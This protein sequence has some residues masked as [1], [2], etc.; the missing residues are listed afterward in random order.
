MK[1]ALLRVAPRALEAALDALPHGR[2]NPRMKPAWRL[3]LG[4]AAV[5]LVLLAKR[6]AKPKDAR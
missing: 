2:F 4:A 3:G 6:S 1:S 5:L